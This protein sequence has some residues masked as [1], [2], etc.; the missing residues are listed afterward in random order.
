MIL[1]R[2]EVKKTE[3]YK[4]FETQ[5]MVSSARSRVDQSDADLLAVQNPEHAL[6]SNKQEASQILTYNLFKTQS[7]I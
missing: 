4:L 5:P 6:V 2:W 3:T 1:A 7:M